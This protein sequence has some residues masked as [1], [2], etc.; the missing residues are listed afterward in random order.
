[1]QFGDPPTAGDP[2]IRQLQVDV[3]VVAH[4]SGRRV[5]RPLCRPDPIISFCT[6]TPGRDLG[7][8]A[9]PFMTIF[10]AL[11]FSRF[12]SAERALLASLVSASTR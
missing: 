11:R 6:E 8:D 2:G 1:M 10:A 3:L 12:L 4:E 5:E 9:H 7:V